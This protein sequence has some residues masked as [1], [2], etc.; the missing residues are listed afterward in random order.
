MIISILVILILMTSL[1]NLTHKNPKAISLRT[2]LMWGQ[3][4]FL[5]FGCRETVW[6][7]L[8]RLLYRSRAL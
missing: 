3:R 7:S 6:P 8:F 4:G 2:S 5:A 1:K